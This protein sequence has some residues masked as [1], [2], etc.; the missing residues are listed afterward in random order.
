MIYQYSCSLYRPISIKYII[1]LLI[2]IIQLVALHI[3]HDNPYLYSPDLVPNSIYN[4]A[5]FVLPFTQGA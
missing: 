1:P 2:W 3:R 4:I 5:P